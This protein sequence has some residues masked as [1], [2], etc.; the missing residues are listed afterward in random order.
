MQTTRHFK[1][2]RVRHRQKRAFHFVLLPKKQ[3][4]NSRNSTCF[5]VIL[6]TLK[7]NKKT[8]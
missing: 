6:V 3:K 4:T 2:L 5:I 7:K 8:K 1:M